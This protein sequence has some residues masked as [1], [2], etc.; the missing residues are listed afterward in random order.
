MIDL[1]RI[2]VGIEVSGR[3]NFYEGLN[4]RASGTKYANPTQNEAVVEVIGLNASTRDHIM[5]ATSP[6]SKESGTK[7]VIV[8]VGRMSS[9]LYTIY[10]GDIIS[11]E[12]SASP[13][14]KLTIRAKTNNAN[15][16]KIV[17]HSGTSLQKLSDIS[18]NVAS[19]NNVSL[20]FEATDRNIANYSYGGA[21][22]K[23][24]IGL[25]RAG[26]VRAFIDDGIL[27]VKDSDK[28]LGGRRRVLSARSGMVGIPT[29]TEKGLKVTYLIDGQSELGGQL[30]VESRMNNSLSGDYVIDQLAFDVATHDSPFFYTAIC[31]RL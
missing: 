3:V 13:D 15:N 14:I 2:R 11:A 1:R 18:R 23:Q 31:T 9:G 6:Y 22:A 28:A 16:Y 27:F 21:A 4:I 30:T 26:N 20:T 7:R 17:T 10:A 24:V 12:V 19:N 8:E 29:A 5:S 25:Q